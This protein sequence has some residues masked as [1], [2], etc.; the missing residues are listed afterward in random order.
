MEYKIYTFCMPI[1][2]KNLCTNFVFVYLDITFKSFLTY[3][4]PLANATFML[5]YTARLYGRL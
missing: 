2:L 5:E 3:F 4:Y 1:F